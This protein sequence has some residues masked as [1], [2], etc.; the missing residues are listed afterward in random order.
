MAN[1]KRK[2][3]DLVQDVL[4]EV[5]CQPEVNDADQIVFMFQGTRFFIDA[6]NNS[7]FIQIFETWWASIGLTN[8]DAEKLKIAINDANASAFPT[9]LWS[10]DEEKKLI[11]VHCRLRT[12]FTEDLPN[13]ADFMRAL[14]TSFFQVNQGVDQLMKQLTGVEDAPAAEAPAEGAN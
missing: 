12:V 10:V 1:E 3:R 7:P 9:V 14:L 13:L 11:G 2:I 4:K 6:D 8:P 5:G